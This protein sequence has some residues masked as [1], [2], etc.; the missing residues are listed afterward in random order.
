MAGRSGREHH[1]VTDL[2]AV[3]IAQLRV[4][5]E[6]SA[7]ALADECARLGG[8]S[9]LTRG[10]I[11]KIECRARRWITPDEAGALAH[12]FGMTV[13]DLLAEKS[14]L[15]VVH[16]AN[17]EIQQDSWPTAVDASDD[18]DSQ[19][20][21]RL[22]TLLDDLEG[23][24]ETAGQPDLVV[25]SGGLTASGGVKEFKAAE[26]FLDDLAKRVR[27]ARHRIVIVPGESDVSRKKCM[28][29]F[30]L[31]EAD[32]IVPEPPYFPKWEHF[33]TM[34]QSL[35]G[36][37]SG[38]EFHP[39]HPWSLFEIVDRNVVIAGLNS[40]MAISHRPE[41][42]Y[43]QVGAEQ[44]DW[45]AR[46]LAEYRD[47]GWLRIGVVGHS[48]AASAPGR[49][50]LRDADLV[51]ARLGDRLNLLLHGCGDT[52]IAALTSEV[53]VLGAGL[54]ERTGRTGSSGTGLPT[55]SGHRHQILQ[56][57]VDGLVR[58]AGHYDPT[59][60]RWVHAGPHGS[61]R[62]SVPRRWQAAETTFPRPVTPAGDEA[63]G[64]ADPV[65][66]PTGRQDVDSMRLALLERIA[67]FYRARDPR[68]DVQFKQ[69]EPPYALITYRVGDDNDV[70]RQV[71]VGACVGEPGRADV[72]AFLAIHAMGMGADSELVYHGDP[73][74]AGLAAEAYRMGIRLRSLIELQGELDLR[75]YVRAQTERLAAD[76]AADSAAA[77]VP[78]DLLGEV[79]SALT[80]ADE[81]RRPVALLIFGPPAQGR[82]LLREVARRLPDLLP[83][84]LP[85]LV[86]PHGPAL[87]DAT[88]ATLEGID[89]LVY[90]YL[91]ARGADAGFTEERFQAKFRDLRARHGRLALLLDN[92]GG[93]LPPAT[94]GPPQHHR[95]RTAR[96]GGSAAPDFAG[97][98][99][100]SMTQYADM[101][102]SAVSGTDKAVVTC[103]V[104]LRPAIEAYAREVAGLRLLQIEDAAGPSGDPLRPPA[105][106]GS[107]RRTLSPRVRGGATDAD[108]G[109]DVE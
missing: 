71:Q 74:D 23:W 12:V 70:L 88:A 47:K 89:D 48:L 37:I 101:L 44:V 56:I 103:D 11:S 9:T 64:A 22:R 85:V 53:P 80:H 32:E 54:T 19:R 95:R 59:G 79:L 45:F 66:R 72:E 25:I 94:A 35:Y 82:G 73:P 51:R 2:L 90:R 106:G 5:R 68:A 84:L 10:A 1:E 97:A 65:D 13:T 61:Y 60:E 7:Q 87:A 14:S 38:V 55:P 105:P 57:T 31:C 108:W 4:Q 3:R 69:G 75:G 109:N 41:D 50:S 78:D 8:P 58:L 91:R 27:L 102:R 92:L 36:E 99:R 26:A 77:A 34:F 104:G 81:A 98:G 100:G 49:R 33:L 30:A 40:T 18:A 21:K 76:A 16:L 62:D 63:G 86:E 17:L 96:V 93:L 6:W 107:R 42:D 67:G 24:H 39:D 28:A 29:Y 43:G 83:D 52:R 46:R 15:T 20:D